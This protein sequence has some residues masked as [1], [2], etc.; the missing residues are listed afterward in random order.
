MIGIGIVS[1]RRLCLV[2]LSSGVL[3]FSG[4]TGAPRSPAAPTPGVQSTATSQ[5]PPA[6]AAPPA[7]GSA[8]QGADQPSPVPAVVR[9]ARTQGLGNIIHLADARGYFRELGIDLHS[10]QFGSAG[11][12]LPALSRG[13]LDVASAPPLP[14]FFNALARDI[15]L[16]L[17]LDASLLTPGNRGYPVLSRLAGGQPVV[18]SPSDVRGKRVAHPARGNPAEPAL[19]RMLD[20][21]GLTVSDLA[22]VQYMGFPEILAAFGGGSADLAIVPEPWGAIAED[23]GLAARIGDA[24][25]YIPNYEI[26]MIVFAEKFGHQQSDVARRFAVGYVR[27][28]RD[29]MDAMEYGRDR[30]AVIALLAESANISPQIL[31]KAGYLAVAR[32]GRINSQTLTTFLNWQVEHGYVPQRPNLDEFLDYQF[33]DD[34]VR[35]LDGAP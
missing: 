24:G 32:D 12:A 1:G 14:S 35:T 33:A 20:E 8:A 18:Q 13:D 15:R 6:A 11:D 10:E 3:T 28:A 2:L 23:R 29:Y 21:V 7:S 17:A 22:D 26:A 16:V 4:C 5:A 25:D 31:S 9:A 27:A 19:D 34:A 30:D